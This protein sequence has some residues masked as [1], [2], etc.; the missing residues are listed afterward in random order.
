VAS[1]TPELTAEDLEELGFG[2]D[3]PAGELPPRISWEEHDDWLDANFGAGMHVSIFAPNEGGKTHLIRYGLMP[4][5]QRYPALILQYKKRDPALSGFG[6]PVKNF[7]SRLQRL[8]YQTRGLDSPAWRDDPE[9][10]RLVLPP[11]RWSA[12][13]RKLEGYKRARKIAGEAID[14]VYHEGGWVLV[15]DEVRRVT[16]PRQPGLGLEAPLENIWQAARSEPVTLIGGTQQPASAPSSMYDQASLV[17]LGK[18][19]DVGRHE[20]LAEIGGNTQL[21]KRTLP[22]LDN[23]EFLFV[24]RQS[25]DMA[26]VKAPPR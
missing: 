26:I 1:R 20:R 25:G 16:D 15:V 8:R 14:R 22:T 19:L 4:H 23:H 2:E 21:I 17:Y 24:H 5:W 11:Y 18:T 12:D 13:G 9:W 6:H 10:F 7:P 3:G